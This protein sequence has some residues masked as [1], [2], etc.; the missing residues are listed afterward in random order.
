MIGGIM[1]KYSQRAASLIDRLS[2]SWRS[3]KAH[4]IYKASYR[5]IV[6]IIYSADKAP[7]K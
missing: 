2:L 1:A 6:E 3:D 4:D 5:D 7:Y